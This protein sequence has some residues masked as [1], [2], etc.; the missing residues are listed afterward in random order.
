[1]DQTI[2]YSVVYLSVA[3]KKKNHLLLKADDEEVIFNLSNTQRN[4]FNSSIMET[5]RWVFLTLLTKKK[6]IVIGKSFVISV[7]VAE[8][9]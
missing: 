2:K 4:P 5:T 3:S 7:S 1:M 8:F 9:L 6:W